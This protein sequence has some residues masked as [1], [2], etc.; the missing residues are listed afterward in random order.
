MGFATFATDLL[1]QKKNMLLW[2]QSSI[3]QREDLLR[4]SLALLPQRQYL[5]LQTQYLSAQ[6]NEYGD[7]DTMFVCSHLKNP[8]ASEP[9]TRVFHISGLSGLRNPLRIYG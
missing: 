1:P 5:L 6:N 4:Q 3:P 7:L 8:F 9:E 2:R